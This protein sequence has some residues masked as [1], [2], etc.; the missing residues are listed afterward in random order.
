MVYCV[1]CGK[2]LAEGTKYCPAC[3]SPVN[4]SVYNEPEPR[5]TYYKK[6]ESGAVAWGIL[7]FFLTIITAVGG[8][9]LCLI[10]YGCDR[11][12]GGFAALLGMLV[13]ILVGVIG[14]VIL[15]VLMASSGNTTSFIG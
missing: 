12:K 6:E 1:I 11:P 9:V 4:A 8:I 2:E 14:V 7:S 13:A 3:G 10:L 5:Y 15:F